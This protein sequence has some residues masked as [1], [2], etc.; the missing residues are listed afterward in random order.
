METTTTL[1]PEIIKE[2]Q[3]TKTFDA[4]SPKECESI[5]KLLGKKMHKFAAVDDFKKFQ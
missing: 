1:H 4:L 5:G 3:M 2:L